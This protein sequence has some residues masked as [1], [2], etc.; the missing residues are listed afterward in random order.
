MNDDDRELLKELVYGV[1]R[2]WLLEYAEVVDNDTMDTE[3][4][5]QHA[6]DTLLDS[7]ESIVKLAEVFIPTGSS[8]EDTIPEPESKE[9]H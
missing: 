6:Q 5:Q 2:E 4:K 7:V 3:K 8:V 9:L 1:V